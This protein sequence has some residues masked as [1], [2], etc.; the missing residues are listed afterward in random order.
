VPKGNVRTAA[1]LFDHLVGEREQFV[2]H[3]E[4]ERLAAA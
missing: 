3:V 4:T 1:D 2:N